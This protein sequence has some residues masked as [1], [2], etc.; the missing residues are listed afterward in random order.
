MSPSETYK[1]GTM[2]YGLPDWNL[3]Q[4]PSPL[5][6]SAA[7]SRVTVSGQEAKSCQPVC[8]RG[9]VGVPRPALQTFGAGTRLCAKGW[10]DSVIVPS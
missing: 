6:L 7:A 5:Y 1:R 8:T 4:V 3:P 9:Q 2:L 10:V